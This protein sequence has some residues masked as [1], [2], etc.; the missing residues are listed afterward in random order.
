MIKAASKSQ[1]DFYREFLMRRGDFSPLEFGCD[2]T[3]E[4]LM[5]L[6]VDEFSQHYRDQLTIDELVLR[7]EEALHFCK[8]VR[9][10]HGFFDL[11]DDIILRCIMT[12]RKRG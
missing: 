6:M 7:P 1:S 10:K 9:R 4:S 12:A 8:S 11:P 2:L 3:R 5:D